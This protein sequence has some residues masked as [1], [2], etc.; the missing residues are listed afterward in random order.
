MY[1]VV[2]GFVVDVGV[3]SVVVVVGVGVVVVVVDVVVDVVVVVVGVVA[4][5]GL[6]VISFVI[7]C[8]MGG[9][10]GGEGGGGGGG[11][12]GGGVLGSITAGA[13]DVGGAT[14]IALAGGG[15]AAV[16]DGVVAGMRRSLPVS[17]K[18]SAPTVTRGIRAA[19]PT[20]A[21]GRRCRRGFGFSITGPVAGRNCTAGRAPRPS[22][23]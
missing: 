15:G 21:S 13:T 23:V 3:A 16:T 11:G 17:V 19:N 12:A 20:S 4:F 14:G 6:G 5:G 7:V 10:G 9:V 22:V 8:V 18:A 1:D 2:I